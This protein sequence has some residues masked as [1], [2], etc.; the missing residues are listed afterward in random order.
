MKHFFILLIRAYQILIGVL[1]RTGFV[2]DTCVFYPTCSAYAILAIEKYGAIK[3][4]WRG[5]KRVA[6]CHPWQEPQ[7]DDV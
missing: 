3:G 5:I 7:V 2:K 4:T 6:R 1:K